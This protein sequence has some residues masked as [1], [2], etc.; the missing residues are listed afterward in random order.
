MD[1]PDSFLFPR[2]VILNRDLS[3]I[4][5]LEFDDPQGIQEFVA[6]SWYDYSSGKA[7]GLHPWSGETTLNYTGPEPPYEHLDVDQSYSWLKSPRWNGNSM[8]VGP[9]ARVLLLYA[10]GH[11][12]TQALVN[13]ALTTLDAPV[14]ALFSTLGRTAARTLET[15]IL[16][17]AMQGWLD[18]LIANIR[19]EDTRTFD[20]SLWEPSTWPKSCQG[21]P[22]T[23][24]SYP[25][26]GMPGH[27][28]P[29]GSRALT[30]RPWR[31]ATRWWIRSSPSRSCARSTV[32]TR[33]SRAPCM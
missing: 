2:G 28:M 19:A 7:S 14:E 6:H 8:E 17:D 30:K 31:T 20:E 10:K 5:D 24:P 4:H 18:A 13:Y 21:V 9:L 3:T 23:R 11:E 33:V 22:T 1:D 15:A 29:T 27:G 26:P 32:S 16:A 12:Q 25:A